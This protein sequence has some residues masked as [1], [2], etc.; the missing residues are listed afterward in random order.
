MGK[1]LTWLLLLAQATAALQENVSS[2]STSS[3]QE[4]WREVTW[5]IPLRDFLYSLVVA[6]VC[7]EFHDSFFRELQQEGKINHNI[8]SGVIP[9]MEDLIKLSICMVWIDEKETI[10][11]TLPVRRRST[12]EWQVQKE[13]IPPRDRP[14]QKTVIVL[15]K[16]ER[17]IIEI[18]IAW[19]DIISQQGFMQFHLRL[20]FTYQ[21]PNTNSRRTALI[22]SS[23]RIYFEDSHRVLRSGLLGLPASCWHRSSMS[24]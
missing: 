21:S 1:S 22:K 19:V 16:Q 2:Q 12:G 18:N 5:E 6:E 23:F 4:P 10:R 3:R 20:A 13:K 9:N 14:I 7:G 11:I 17:G 15:G 24:D 8:S